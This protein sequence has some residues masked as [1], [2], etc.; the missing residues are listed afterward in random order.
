LLF[1]K[2]AAPISRTERFFTYGEFAYSF[3]GYERGADIFDIGLITLIDETYWGII[4]SVEKD[5][6]EESNNIIVRGYCLKALTSSRVTYPPGFTF[7]Q[8]GGTA[9]YDAVTGS[10]EHCMKHYITRNFFS[11]DSPSRMIPGFMVA[12]NKDRGTPDDRYMTRFEPLSGVLEALGKDAGLGY[13]IT[14]DLISG[15]IVFDCVEGVD[16]S[17]LQSDRPR[18]V[19]DVAMKNIKNMNYLKNDI[20]MKNVFYASLSGSE[21][22]DEVYTATVTRGDDLPAGLDRWEQHFDISASHPV[23]GA[24]L[25]ELKRLT[26]A[27]SETYQTVKTFKAQALQKDTMRYGINY[28]LGDIVTVK[29]RDWGI[30][31]HPRLTEMHLESKD[32]GEIYT[33]TFGTAPINFIERLRRQIRGG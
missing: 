33:A 28:N 3:P 13:K 8:I 16:R 14:P 12:D 32:D 31:M 21:F 24:E 4:K 29:D 7:E 27:R 17:A 22:M 2:R 30:S 10:T 26:L 6:N 23:P 1:T 9:G 25:D 15:Q 20:H 19:F 11:E 18:M 5:T